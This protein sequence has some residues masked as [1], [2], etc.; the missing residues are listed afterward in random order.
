MPSVA[1]RAGPPQLLGGRVKPD[2]SPSTRARRSDSFALSS[3]PLRSSITSLCLRLRPRVAASSCRTTLSPV[4]SRRDR[5]LSRS[6]T[7]PSARRA[8]PGCCRK[9]VVASN[10]PDGL[11]ATAAGAL[12]PI[13][14]GEPRP[15][16][17]RRRTRPRTPTPYSG[18]K[19]AVAS[20]PLDGLNATER[21][22]RA[23][24]KRGARRPESARRRADR[25]HR[26]RIGDRSWR[27]RAARRT[28]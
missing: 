4:R 9:L 18:P 24:R 23:G 3:T 15:R 10:P 17:S 14:N 19:L 13:V 6:Q 26:H 8:T 5:R 1:E 21:G 25:E 20:S 16:S 11:N 12:P 2:R 22:V 27:P 28:G 7:L